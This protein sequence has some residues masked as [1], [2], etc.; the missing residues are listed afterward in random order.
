M[1]KGSKAYKIKANDK[2]IEITSK[3]VQNLQERT[4]YQKDVYIFEEDAIKWFNCYSQYLKRNN[5]AICMSEEMY[6][7][8][9]EFYTYL[10]EGEE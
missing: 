3:E 10:Q 7:E 6:K 1:S 4:Y 5:M 2:I 8:V 9:E